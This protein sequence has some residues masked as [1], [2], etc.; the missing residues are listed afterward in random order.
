MAILLIECL[1]SQA[2]IYSSFLKKR[3]QKMNG[4]D[5]ANNEKKKQESS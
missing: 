4:V 1:F 2:Y 3:I 5:A